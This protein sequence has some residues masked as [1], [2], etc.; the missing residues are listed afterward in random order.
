MVRNII[1]YATIKTVTQQISHTLR[2][3]QNGSHFANNIFKCIFFH[4]IVEFRLKFHW[5]LF[6]RVQL[7][8]GFH[9]FKYWLSVGGWPAIIWTN[10]GLVYWCIYMSLSFH[11]FNQMVCYISSRSMN[12]KIYKGA[13]PRDIESVLYIVSMCPCSRIM[14]SSAN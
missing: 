3:T 14:Q 4:E 10:D 11:E 6:L 9:W 12:S 8:T 13:W 7:T 1:W 5:N 2:P